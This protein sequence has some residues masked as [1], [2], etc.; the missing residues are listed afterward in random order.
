MT[1]RPT[2]CLCMI[3]KDEVDVLGSCLRSCRDLIDYWVICDTGS[4]D[5]TPELIRRELEGV[6]GE[7]HAHRWVHFGHNRTELMKIARDK[8]DYSLILD[9]DMTLEADTAALENLTAD[10]YLLRHAG[11]TRYY[12][13]RLVR[14]RLAWRYEGAVHEYIVSDEE[15]TTGRLQQV[16]INSQSVGAVR[17]GRWDRDAELLEAALERDPRDE[18]ATF[19]LAQTYRDIGLEHDDLA[20]LRR[21]RDLYERRA[22]MGG[23]VEETYCAWHQAGLLS[24]RADDWPKA[25]DAFTHAWETRPARLE[26]VHDLALGLIERGLYHS[27]HQYTRIASLTRSLPVP[28]DILFVQPWIYEWGLLFQHSIAA[29]W[30][31]EFDATIAACKRL[32]QIADLPGSHRRQTIRNA[33]YALREQ[34]REAAQRGISQRV[35]THVGQPT[36]GS[37]GR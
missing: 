3:V 21:A 31:G 28:D 10:A 6:P 8:A 23:W 36:R 1:E 24:A 15:R 16:S 9:A 18:R 4:T 5:G 20:S 11:P 22:A 25:A 19:Y 14:G 7:L 30:C 13:K 17:N 26:A 2:L 37:S 33:E 12:T 34:A 32:L 29:Y 27:A 35:W